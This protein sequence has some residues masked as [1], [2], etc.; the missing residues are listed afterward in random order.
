MGL[1]DVNQAWS[2]FLEGKSKS[3]TADIYIH[4]FFISNILLGLCKKIVLNPKKYFKHVFVR[5]GRFWGNF[6]FFKQHLS[7]SK[8]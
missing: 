3:K 7:L 1:K 4:A 2:L 8:K 5:Q 6:L